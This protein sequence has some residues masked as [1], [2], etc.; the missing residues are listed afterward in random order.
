MGYL[1][2]VVIADNVAVFVNKVYMLEQPS[3]LLLVSG[4]LAF[5]V[6]IF[7]DFSAYTDLARGFA[8]LL[9]FDLVVNFN[10][11]YLAISPSDFWRR[12]HISFSSWI[13]D[14]LYIPLGGSRVDSNLKFL[15]VTVTAMGLSGLWH[16]AAW[17]YVAWGVYH[18]LLVFIY[19]RLGKG[20]RWQPSGIANRVVAW[21]VMF[22]AT[23]IGWMLFRAPSMGWLL[24]A[25]GGGDL[26]LSGDSLTASVSILGMVLL[27]S[28]PL[29]AL[30]LL[31][32]VDQ[33]VPY[34]RPVYYAVAV[35]AVIV[36]LGTGGQD[37]IYFQF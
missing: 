1:K 29:M 7:A 6:Q 24:N 32:R 35:S 14:Y 28:L 30:P 8:R 4:T 27:Y 25:V 23:N 12:W 13:R 10:A 33:R 11:P 5:T 17:H 19:H 9:G 22:L 37:F 2:K 21:A 18:A 36:F 16:G 20:G 15:F 3:L 34:L 26:G 31:E